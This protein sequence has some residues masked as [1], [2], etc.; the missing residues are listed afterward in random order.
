[1]Q[2]KQTKTVFGSLIEILAVV[3][4]LLHVL[5]VLGTWNLLPESI[6]VHFNFAGQADA[7]GERS[8]IILLFGLNVL[9]YVG[10]TWLARY[11]QKFN[12]PWKITQN[13]AGRQYHLVRI[14]MKVIKCQTVWLFAIISLQTRGISL[15]QANSLG[16]LFVPLVITITS[17]TV[18][19]Y[20]VVA[21]RSAF[22]E[23]R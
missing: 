20:F 12:Y 9:F 13:N 19:G 17:A 8:D 4:L 18:I 16:Y 2:D 1:M 6:P 11:P 23:K 5:T 3:G 22:G 21:S 14:F 7:S 10:L 15:G